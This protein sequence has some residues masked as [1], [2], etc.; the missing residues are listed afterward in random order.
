V[1]LFIRAPDFG[2]LKPLCSKARFFVFE[3]ARKICDTNQ[4]QEK[5]NTINP[6]DVRDS[7]RW[8]EQERL[9]TPLTQD[10]ETVYQLAHERMIP[11]VMKLSGKILPKA[12]QANE[13]LNKQVKFWM[14]SDYNSRYLLGWRELWL[15]KRQQASLLWGDKQSQKQ[16]LIQKSQE[17]LLLFVGVIGLTFLLVVG[18][19][20][21]LNHTEAGQLWQIRRGLANWTE[22]VNDPTNQIEAVTAF[23]KDGD[24][25]QALNIANQIKDD[26]FK[27]ITLSVIAET[28]GKLNQPEE[29]AKLLKLA[30]DSA[31]RIKDESKAEVLSAIA[32]A[33]GKLNQP[34]EAAQWLKQALDSA[35]RIKDDESKVIKLSAIAEAYGKL[36]QPQ[37]AA[38]LLKQALD[39]A[40]QLQDDSDKVDALRAIAEAIGKLNQHEEGA[41]L[42][43]QALDSANQIQEDYFKVLVLSAIAE[44]YI[45]L[46]QP[47]KATKLLKQ[48]LDSANQIKD[49]RFKAY[50]LSAISEAYSKLN[51][52]EQAAKLLTQALDSANKIQGDYYNPHSAAQSRKKDSS[53]VLLFSPQVYC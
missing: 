2:F 23:A 41:K 24:L 51:Q 44:A 31:N 14:E 30:L 17:R 4:L 18:T 43:K 36:N 20:G 15:I 28:I 11:A 10:E 35:N 53:F 21:G 5:L 16:K 12:Y 19:W 37:E 26:Y 22:Q 8:L 50:A 7:L 27:V 6:K 39:S 34:E 25:P 40:N 13:L 1:S 45:K 33:I 46:N 3:P 49:D 32:E 29:A 47:E 38:K 52:S 42:L 9:I 48:A